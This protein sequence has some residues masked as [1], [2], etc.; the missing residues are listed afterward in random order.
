MATKILKDGEAPALWHYGHDE[1]DVVSSKTFGFWLYMLSDALIFAGLFA[2]YA[3][4][5]HTMNFADGPSEAQIVHPIAAFGQTIAVLTSV[6]AYS[7]ATVAMKHG[8]KRGVLLGIAVA[9]ALGAVFIALEL[10]DFASL[11]AMN[12]TPDRSGFLSAY[13]VLIATHG[14]HMAFG[15]LW[16]LVMAVQV[17]R[18]GFTTAVVAQLLNLRLFWQFQAAVWVCVYV[19]VYLKG[20]I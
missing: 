18:F 1:H 6:L 4:L 2:A 17:V 7:L 15:I 10:A 12:A 5:D 20:A 16:L 13:F 11:F 8:N 14:L 19:F 3:V 9:L